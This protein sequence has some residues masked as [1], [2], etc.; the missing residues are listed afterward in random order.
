MDTFHIHIT[1]RVQGVGFRPF[2][3]KL[4]QT[5]HLKGWVCN[6]TDG[7]HIRFNATQEQANE[8]YQACLRQKPDQSVVNQSTLSKVATEC[9]ADFQIVES[10]SGKLD[11]CI[12]PDF[13]LCQHCR[14]E[15]Y[16]PNNHRFHYA[17][18]TCTECGPRYS[19]MSGLPYDRELTAMDPF[20][21]C[22][23]C[24]AEYHDPNDRR[25]FSQTNSCP[26]CGVQ[27]HL[28][29][30]DG[31]VSDQLTS[32]E[33]MDLAV[34]RLR[35]DKIIAVK[36]IGGYLLLCNAQ[37][38]QAV[39]ELRRRKQR[40]SKPFAVLYG[41][42]E[43]VATQ[44]HITQEETSL[45]NG[46][47]SPVVLLNP[48]QHNDLPMD[49]VA[50]GLEKIG[51]MVPYAPILELVSSK[52][53]SPLIATSA[54]QS[55]SPIVHADDETGLF[56]LADYVLSHNR[57]I[58]FPQDDSVVQLSPWNQQRIVL[59]RSRGM[60]PST[61]C[62]LSNDKMDQLA[63]GAE[64]KGT[65]AYGVG[66]NTYVSQYLGNLSHYDNQLQFEEVLSR[67]S[68]L[69][70]PAIKQI[71]IDAHPGY[72]T[73]QLGKTWAK[74]KGISLVEIPH[75]EAHFAAILAERKLTEE[76][77]V[78]GV[79]WDGTGFGSDGNSWGGEFFEYT[80]HTI[81][82]IAH[83][84]YYP[85]LSQDRMAIDNRLCALAL[86]GPEN[87][88]EL[89]NA[90]NS[91]EWSFYLKSMQRPSLLT[92]SMGRVFDAV[93]FLADIAH[94]NT[95]E[96]QSAMLLEQNAQKAFSKRQNI[97]PYSF[98]LKGQ[99]LE[100][101]DTI[102]QIF[103]DRKNNYQGISARF[104]LTLVEMI[105]K[106]ANEGAYQKIAFSGGVFQNGLLTDLI[107]NALGPVFDLYFHQ[108]LSPNDENIAY[109]QLAHLQYIDHKKNRN[110]KPIAQCV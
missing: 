31:V 32:E 38:R 85:Q 64:M 89:Q 48:R 37:S 41:S 36:G 69:I 20:N 46:S 101:N 63:L 105:R 15:L 67:F 57:A 50:P 92:S 45:L 43:T 28:A 98:T 107:I 65:F 3:Y 79:I 106:V 14:E 12:T 109:G 39:S 27:M 76:N 74:E 96:G 84:A 11:L 42:V 102:D 60:A 13:S 6:A 52:F 8:F 58:V 21:M 78:L 90:F 25:Y 71:A 70:N 33:L 95:Y 72:F 75:H 91:T 49:I 9:F 99:Q 61:F 100:L 10:H 110:L 2:V 1:G 93:A 54:N 66:S 18:I 59:R 5:S 56:Q 77:H 87:R 82:R 47:I 68:K 40:P 86:S 22:S 26:D 19:V 80:N 23:A 53:G 29:D 30:A 108:E 104:H 44:F 55:G 73:H 35:E 24:E 97:Q 83:L 34:E 94:T 51:V 7:V 88:H 4:A 81:T 103:H 62:S 17:F 16:D